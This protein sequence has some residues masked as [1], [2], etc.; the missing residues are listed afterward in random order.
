MSKYNGS[1]PS[2]S[3]LAIVEYLLIDMNLNPGVVN[4]LIDFVLKINNNKLVKSYVDKIA[5]QWAKSKIETVEDAMEISLKEYKGSKQ[6]KKPKIE[7]KPDWFD[8]D[9]EE[10]KASEDEIKELEELLNI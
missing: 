5:S 7:E 9:I 6:Y 2:K 3:D 4:V 8:K 10:N 1:K